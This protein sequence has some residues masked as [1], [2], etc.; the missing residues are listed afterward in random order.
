MNMPASEVDGL[1]NLI[2]I[3]ANGG[4]R[5]V[6]ASRIVDSIRRTVSPIMEVSADVGRVVEIQAM[7]SRESLI[8]S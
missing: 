5:A 6:V 4:Q 3:K 1:V 7:I 8:K 2:L